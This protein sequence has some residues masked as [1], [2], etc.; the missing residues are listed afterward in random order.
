MMGKLKNIFS[1][2]IQTGLLCFSVIVV[3]HTGKYIEKLDNVI[4]IS[5]ILCEDVAELEQELITFRTEWKERNVR[6]K[7]AF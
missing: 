6:S 2:A 5:Q 1:L 7:E 4:R 3:F